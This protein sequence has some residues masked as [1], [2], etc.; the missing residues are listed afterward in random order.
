M[1][2]LLFLVVIASFAYGGKNVAPPPSEPIPVPVPVKVPLGFYF[3]AG[4]SYV[5]SKCKC[6]PLLTSN[7]YKENEHKGNSSGVNLKVGYEF[8]PYL[9]IEAKYFYTPWG[10]SDKTVKHYGLYLKPSYPLTEHIDIYALLGYGKT[11]CQTLQ[12]SQND[13][14]WGVGASYHMN[15]RIKDKKEGFGIYLEYLRPLHKTDGKTIKTDTIHTGLQY[16]F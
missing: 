11:D 3:G 6:A 13:F 2:K 5:H 8:N 1:K 9:A 10:D 7:G 16:N 15:K 12:K 14:S 4:F